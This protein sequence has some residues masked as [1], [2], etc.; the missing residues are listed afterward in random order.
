MDDLSITE[1]HNSLSTIH[2]HFLPH[3]YYAHH[4]KNI[5]IKCFD[6]IYISFKI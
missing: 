5:Y 4:A 3:I 2:E 6:Y 1:R